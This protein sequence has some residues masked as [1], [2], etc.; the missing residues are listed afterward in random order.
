MLSSCVASAAHQTISGAGP[1]D[2]KA[3]LVAVAVASR[4]VSMDEGCRCSEV[5]VHT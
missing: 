1:Q 4:E 3:C 2:L 5:S